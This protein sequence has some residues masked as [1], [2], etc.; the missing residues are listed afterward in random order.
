MLGSSKI[1]KSNRLVP[2]TVFNDGRQAKLTRCHW[3][4]DTFIATQRFDEKGQCNDW[5]K[6]W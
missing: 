6:K 2:T 3:L 4:W 5:F 1:I